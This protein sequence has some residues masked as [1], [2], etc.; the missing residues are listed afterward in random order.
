MNKMRSL[1]GQRVSRAKA[2]GKE[3]EGQE[4]EEIQESRPKTSRTPAPPIVKTWPLRNRRLS[5]S[6]DANSSRASVS[7]SDKEDEANTSRRVSN[8]KRRREQNDSPVPASTNEITNKRRGTRNQLSTL[9][10]KTTRS[11]TMMDNTIDEEDQEEVE[12]QQASRA[13]KPKRK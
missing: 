10:N 6:S 9:A 11:R 3:E 2:G 5:A 8:V 12:E 1:R 13:K 7:P 4:E